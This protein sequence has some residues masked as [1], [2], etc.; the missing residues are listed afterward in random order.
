MPKIQFP[1]EVKEDEEGVNRRDPNEQDELFRSLPEDLQAACQEHRHLWDYLCLLPFDEV[2][3][4]EYY[5][6]LTRSLGDRKEHNL[7]Y[8]VGEGIF[9]HLCSGSGGGRATYIAI[10]PGLTEDLSNV[11]PLIE[12][13]LVDETYDLGKARSEEEKADAFIKLVEKICIERGN[14][15]GSIPSGRRKD[16]VKKGKSKDKKNRVQVTAGQLKALKHIIVRDKVGMGIIDPMIR[17]SY[18]E[19]ISCSGVGPIFLEHK[20]FKGIKTATVFESHD[21]LDN[22]VLNLSES[23]KKPVT[24]R[25]PIV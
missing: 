2:T 4:P 21:D 7:I 9:V 19:D 15:A 25:R 11:L 10:E 5:T 16:N 18:I 20:V 1:F 12:D 3:V 14:Y 13:K 23:I 22:F 8:T 24:L 6:E 17:D